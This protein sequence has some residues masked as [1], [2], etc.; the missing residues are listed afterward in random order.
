MVG[1]E[2]SVYTKWCSVDLNALP[3]RP[4]RPRVVFEENSSSPD[5]PTPTTV[6]DLADHP[7]G[8]CELK[9]YCSIKPVIIYQLLCHAVNMVI[10]LRIDYWLCGSQLFKSWFMCC[11]RV[12]NCCVM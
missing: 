11:K 1:C 4:V 10:Y 5:L 8:K 12:I 3:C 6:P 2:T 7:L 9:L